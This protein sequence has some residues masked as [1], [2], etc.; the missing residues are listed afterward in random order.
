MHRLHSPLL[1]PALL[2][3]FTALRPAV[4]QEVVVFE[5][6]QVSAS[7]GSVAWKTPPLSVPVKYGVGETID[8]NQP[9]S[10]G[11]RL[12]FKAQPAPADPTW[13]VEIL[14][15]NDAVLWTYT[16]S[17]GE[18]SFW[19]AEVRGPRVRV[20]VVNTLAD[21]PLSVAVDG[22]A[23]TQGPLPIPQSLTLPDDREPISGQSP[24][25]KDLGK[26]VARIR[27]MGDDNLWYL[28]TGF[29]VSPDLLMTNQHCPQSESEWRSALVDFDFD[30]PGVVP[31]TT[32][33]KQFVM[34]SPELDLSIFRLAGPMSGRA[35][36]KLDVSIPRPAA[37]SSPGTEMIVI[38]HPFGQ[39]KQVSVIDCK[40]DRV[41]VPGSSLTPTDFEHAC[42]T[43]KGSSGAAVLDL[44]TNKVVGLHH[45]GF[46]PTDQR[47]V[48]RAVLMQQIVAFIRTK[49]PD[50]AAEIGL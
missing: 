5:G 47:L 21:S 35:P 2:I 48:N 4:A 41:P 18:V 20:R 17:P 40:A 28:C 15:I 14:S 45:L 23:F 16:P 13:M 44:S 37:P 9:S 46:R 50:I 38:Q 7:Y 22:V 19:S 1:L 30:A 3:I 26:A 6:E 29:L 34:T 39:P 31:K 11:L 43:L 36:L 27:Y 24:E 8:V 32:T 33:F 42:D 49:R 10:V 25:I 12:H